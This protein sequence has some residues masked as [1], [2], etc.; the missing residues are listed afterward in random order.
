MRNSLVVLADGC[1][2]RTVVGDVARLMLAPVR[3]GRTLLSISFAAEAEPSCAVPASLFNGDDAS[4]SVVPST[5]QNFSA[6]S[7]STRLHC[8]QR[9][10]VNVR[11]TSVCR[12]R[13]SLPGT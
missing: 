5:R 8:G 3:W 9:F 11:Q 13:Y 2:G 6:S 1:G 10:I 12:L 4:T 7:V